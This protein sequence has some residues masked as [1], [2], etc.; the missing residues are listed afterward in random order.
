MGS[1]SNK[2][3]QASNTNYKKIPHSDIRTRQPRPG[4]LFKSFLVHLSSKSMVVLLFAVVYMFK[5][6]NLLSTGFDKNSSYQER[7]NGFPRVHQM[8]EI[9]VLTPSITWMGP[10]HT[11]FTFDHV[12]SKIISQERLFHVVGSPLVENCLGATTV[13]CLHTTKLF[14]CAPVS[15][16][17]WIWPRLSRLLVLIFFCSLG[18]W[19]VSRPVVA[20]WK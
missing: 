11:R 14:L 5:L 8:F 16:L 4:E 6:G 15:I 17:Q 3:E 20:N 9:R 7:R 18:Y 2:T 13:A 12:A 1:W 10:P 19:L